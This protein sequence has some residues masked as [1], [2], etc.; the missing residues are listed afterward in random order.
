MVLVKCCPEIAD[1][2]GVGSGEEEKKKGKE[3]ERGAYGEFGVVDGEGLQFR[4]H[5]G[6]LLGWEEAVEHALSFGEEAIS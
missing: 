3:G 6:A 5:L 4:Y 2:C 1:A